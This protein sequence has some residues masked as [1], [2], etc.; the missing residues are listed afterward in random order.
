M[1]P[2]QAKVHDFKQQQSQEVMSLGL[3]FLAV[4]VNTMANNKNRIPS[5]IVSSVIFI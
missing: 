4:I 1:L 3:C 2:T 5:K